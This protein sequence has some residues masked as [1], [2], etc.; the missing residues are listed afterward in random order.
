MDSRISR[1]RSKLAKVPYQVRRSHSMG[2]ERH[3][4]RVGPRISSAQAADFEGEHHIELPSAYQ[5]FLVELGG[6][7]A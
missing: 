5:K 4:F 6:S 2:A 1:I 7:G 3:A